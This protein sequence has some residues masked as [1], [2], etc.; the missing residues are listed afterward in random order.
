MVPP[1]PG[2]SLIGSKPAGLI[3]DGLG[4][5]RHEFGVHLADRVHD[6]ER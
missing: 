1:H 3:A 6:V 2:R 5:Q 4:R